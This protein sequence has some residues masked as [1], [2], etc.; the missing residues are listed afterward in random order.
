MQKKPAIFGHGLTAPFQKRS[1]KVGLFM[2][3]LVY[4]ANKVSLQKAQTIIAGLTLEAVLSQGRLLFFP[5]QCLVR[6]S[7]PKFH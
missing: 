1:I 4:F 2:K 6:K 7:I 5:W 3:A